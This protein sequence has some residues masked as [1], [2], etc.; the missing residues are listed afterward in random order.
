MNVLKCNPGSSSLSGH[1]KPA[2]APMMN[3]MDRKLKFGS[4]VN[5]YSEVSVIA[6][7]P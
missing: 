2:K 3:P 6:S 4:Q 1:L 5:P 7:K